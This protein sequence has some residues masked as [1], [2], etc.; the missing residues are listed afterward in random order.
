MKISRSV[1][2]EYYENEIDK[3]EDYDLRE[4][5]YKKTWELY[6]IAYDID[7]ALE[8]HVK[9]P[10]SYWEH[11]SSWK[12]DKLDRMSWDE[13]RERYDIRGARKSEPVD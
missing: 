11:D 4:E 8:E 7:K 1:I 10:K 12:Q 9:E 13:R 3:I 5:L 2:Q 6:D